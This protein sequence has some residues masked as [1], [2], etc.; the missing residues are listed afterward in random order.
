MNYLSNIPRSP[1]LSFDLGGRV[2][3]TG[4]SSGSSSFERIFNPIA[5]PEIAAPTEPD[6][7]EIEKEYGTIRQTLSPRKINKSMNA[8]IDTTRAMSGQA[9]DNASKAY[10]NRLM[11]MGVAPLAGGVVGA[12]VKM[13]GHK[14][15]NALTVQKEQMVQEAK[16]DASLI[17]AQM[18]AEVGKLREAYSRTLADY[19]K[20]KAS[21]T[22]QANMF[23]A[24]ELRASSEFQQTHD[25]A[26]EELAA[27]LA[28]MEAET[29]KKSPGGGGGGDFFPGYI[30]GPIGS[31]QPGTGYRG[32]NG[33]N[34]MVG[35]AS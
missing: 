34:V 30:P 18:A 14:E 27:K 4:S 15:A 2:T 28:A 3:G 12:Q 9:A 32:A 8:L 31:I 13:A 20:S 26:A 10:S 33:H 22:Q 19:N 24:S 11:Q 5:M 17:A 21:L 16:K 23:N 29:A 7:S 35:W 1:N 6:Y 25:L